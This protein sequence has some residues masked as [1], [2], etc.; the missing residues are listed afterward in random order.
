M[1]VYSV[2]ELSLYLVKWVP[3]SDIQYFFCYFSLDVR[4]T[5]CLFWEDPEICFVNMENN[6]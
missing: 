2:E 3:E 4:S 5:Y 6:H 1:Y